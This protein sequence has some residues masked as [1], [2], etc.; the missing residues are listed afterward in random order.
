MFWKS[1]S[2]E[3]GLLSLKYDRS[4]IFKVYSVEKHRLLHSIISSVFIV[5]K[6]MNVN[7]CQENHI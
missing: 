2:I 7:R 4:I 6:K 1:V 3:N 5:K